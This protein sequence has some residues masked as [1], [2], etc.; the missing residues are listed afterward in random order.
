MSLFFKADY[1]LRKDNSGYGVFTYQVTGGTPFGKDFFRMIT[2]KPGLEAFLFKHATQIPEIHFQVEEAPISF[3]FF[4]SGSCT[5]HINGMG[6]KKEF[7]IH[8]GTN[9]IASLSHVNGKVLLTPQENL[10]SLDLKIDRG[11][12]A[13]YLEGLPPSAHIKELLHPKTHGPYHILPMTGA[14]A[15]TAMATLYP[16]GE[17]TGAALD[18]YYESKVLTLLSLQLQQLQKMDK[19]LT[20]QGHTTGEIQQFHAAKEILE[21]DLKEA[22]TIAGLARQ[23]G[24]NEFK[25]KKGFKEIFGTT[26]FTHLQKKKM[27]A[28]WHYLNQ[29]NFTVSQA[30]A[31]V[32]YTN[33]SHFSAAFRKHFHLNPGTLKKNRI[34]LL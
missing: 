31:E 14:M 7:T 5:H 1:P 24:L 34:H 4:L 23:C 21:S 16:P 28:A 9:I 27:E 29:E 11:L 32:G 15:T 3:S 17:L 26:I 19:S 12:L 25:L 33:V 20:L 8:G 22:P 30:A 10:G 13:T 6:K 18:L 2:I